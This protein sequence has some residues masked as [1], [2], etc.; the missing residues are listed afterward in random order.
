M[1]V[2]EGTMIVAREILFDCIAELNKRWKCPKCGCSKNSMLNEVCD[3][4]GK[5]IDKFHLH[6]VPDAGAENESRRFWAEG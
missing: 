3:R 5:E 1:K 4:C 2:T 6:Y